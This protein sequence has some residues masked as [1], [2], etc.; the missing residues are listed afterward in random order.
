ML[1]LKNLVFIIFGAGLYSFALNYLVI[2]NSLYEG[3]VTGLTLIIYYLWHLKPS[4]MN[5]IINIP[6]FVLGWHI[7][8]RSIFYKS[9][10]GTIAV[11]VWLAI[12]ERLPLAIDLE[13]DLMIIVLLTGILMGT[14]LGIIFKAGG[15]TGGSDILARIGH[16]YTH[17]S[18]GQIMLA[19]DAL[20]LLLTV[21]ISKDLRVVLYTL[22]LVTV[23]TRV[24]DMVGEGGYGSKG[25]MIMTS[26]SVELA[27]AIDSEIERGVT[28]IKGQ[29]FYS[30]NDMNIVYSVI[31]KS[32]LQ[33][34]KDLIKRIDPFAFITITDAY[35]V[36]GEGFTHD[37][38]KQAIVK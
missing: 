28:Y 32:Q 23:A 33:E 2:P 6:L 1:R 26:K 17:Y 15:T 27:T 12:F 11:T 13:G 31:D 10:L 36:L 7:L 4:I 34:M 18:I 19:I 22:I 37:E 3:G 29:G 24:I 5:I 20:V 38:N 30:Q 9:L 35:E 8:G 21:V 25:V 14:G 16:K